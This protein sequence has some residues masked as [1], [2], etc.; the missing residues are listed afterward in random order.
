MESMKLHEAIIK[1]FKESHKECMT[2][3][4]IANELN[5]NGWYKKKDKSPIEANQIRA[6][7]RKYP[8]LFKPIDSSHVMLTENCT[9]PAEKESFCNSNI[10]K[11]T[12]SE[13][14]IK[15]IEAE[16]MNDERFVSPEQGIQKA[17]EKAGIYCIRIKDKHKLPLPCQDA[18]AKRKHDILY[19]GIATDLKNRLRQE[20][21]AK[22][23]G[24]FFRSLGAIL[25]FTPP[26]GSL[27]EKSNKKN[28]TFS[29]ED[30]K[31][32]ILF[33]RE[34]LIINYVVTD[35]RDEDTETQ[36][37]EKYRPIINL[38]K[39]PEKLSFVSEQRKFCVNIANRKE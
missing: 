33:I 28:Y 19:I 2:F 30:E 39:N 13:S 10:N 18:L 6:R 8:Q 1:L 34:N 37:I 27:V 32:I 11:P 17:P 7:V 24:T 36:L 5:R 3:Q 31:K 35:N 29:D 25:D 22:G 21:E 12:T 23:H 16:L 9:L 14:K 4:E 15:N 20:L 38:D 26:K